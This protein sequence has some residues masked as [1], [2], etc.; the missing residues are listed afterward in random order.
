MF[1]RGRRQDRADRPEVL[2]GD[3]EIR[4]HVEDVGVGAQRLALDLGDAGE[5]QRQRRDTLEKVRGREGGGH[6][7]AEAIDLAQG[8]R[9]LDVA[10]LVEGLHRDRER[11]EGLAPQ[12]VDAF[13]AA[14]MQHQAAERE[15]F[16]QAQAAFAHQRV[17]GLDLDAQFL[18]F[19]QLGEDVGGAVEERPGVHRALDSLALRVRLVHVGAARIIEPFA[20]DVDAVL[21]VVEQAPGEGLDELLLGVERVRWR[22]IDLEPVAVLVNAPDTVDDGDG[23]VRGGLVHGCGASALG[24][25]AKHT[26]ALRRFQ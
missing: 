3:D 12:L 26:P 22:V 13:V 14:A 11:A 23:A 4:P 9:D 19:H 5:F 7:R 8:L 21:D 2:G 17:V 16:L 25:E 1:G 18:Q 10:A 6:H 20:G 24:Q 15:R